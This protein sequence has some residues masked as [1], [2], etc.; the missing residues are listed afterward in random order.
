MYYLYLDESGDLGFDLVNKNSSKFFTVCILLIKSEENKKKIIKSLNRTLHKKLNPKNKRNRIVQELKGTSTTIEVKKYFYKKIID[1]DFHIY[2]ITL[3]KIRVYDNLV[4]N[5]SRVYNW[6]VRLLLDNVDFSEVKDRIY[7]IIDKSKSK[8]Q[9]V[10]FNEYI[11]RQLM[12]KIDP[13]IPLEIKHKSSCSDYGLNAVDLFSW[14]I[15]RKY[16]RKKK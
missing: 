14:G 15:F 2:S 11:Y 9:I 13:K 6:I 16:E 1:L 5:K 12:A 10:E 7:L 8:P 4:K 3:N